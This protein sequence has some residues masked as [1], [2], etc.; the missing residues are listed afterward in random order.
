ELDRYGLVI[1]RRWR[2]IVAIVALTALVSAVYAVIAPSS[3]TASTQLLIDPISPQA[4]NVTTYYYPPYYQELA[5]Q[6]ILD[7]FA[8]VIEGTTFSQQVIAILQ[9]SP[10]ADVKAYADKFRTI[11]DAQRLS[12]QFTIN[13]INR[14]LQVQVQA[15]TRNEALAIAAAADQIVRQQGPAIF[16]QL[17]QAQTSTGQT[18]PQIATVSVGVSD[19]PHITVKPSRGHE[20]LFWLLRT[21]VG[22]VAALAIVLVL[23]YFDDRPYDAYDVREMLGLPVLGAV[24]APAL[25]P[26]AVARQRSVAEREPV[27]AGS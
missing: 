5:A 23:H 1:R 8:G 26:T 15:S 19:A 11:D 14:L 2:L 6:F 4:A 12:K 27:T 21:A 16:A 24:S 10:Q 3:Y 18:P 7:D 13:R 22:L 9:Q 20:A 25:G 17:T